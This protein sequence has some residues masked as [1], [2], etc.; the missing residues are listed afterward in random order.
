METRL[1][2]RKGSLTR[3]SLR[4]RD[5]SRSLG[6]RGSGIGLLIRASKLLRSAKPAKLQSRTL[7]KNPAMQSLIQIMA[8]IESRARTRSTTR[9]FKKSKIKRPKRRN[10]D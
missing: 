4:W 7:A 1:I 9:S 3:R 2:V 8:V 5:C 6:R 10:G